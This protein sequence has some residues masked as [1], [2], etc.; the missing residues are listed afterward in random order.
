MYTMSKRKS[1]DKQLRTA[2]K[3]GELNIYDP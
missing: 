2:S 3:L 1:E